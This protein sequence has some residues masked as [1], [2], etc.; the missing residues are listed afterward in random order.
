MC[1]TGLQ[2]PE[3]QLL[4]CYGFVRVHPGRVSVQAEDGR[5]GQSALHQQA[6]LAVLKR[7]QQYSS[8]MSYG[9][10]RPEGEFETT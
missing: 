7:A 10:R 6:S 1:S 9:P 8:A 2:L 4:H 3:R 5:T